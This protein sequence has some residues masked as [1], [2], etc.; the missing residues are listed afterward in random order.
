MMRKYIKI[1]V[2]CCIIAISRLF[3]TPIKYWCAVVRSNIDFGPNVKIGKHTYGITQKTIVIASSHCPASVVV[4]SFCS[5]APGVIILA[6][7]DH[8]TNLPS[9]FPFKTLLY[10]RHKESSTNYSNWDA[11]TKG[12]V[13]IG[14]DVWLGL[15]TIIL[16]GV[17]IGP[18]A[19]IGAGSVVT[20]D[21]PPYAIAVGNPAKVIKFRFSN[22]IIE[23]LLESEWWLFSDGMLKDLAPF[24][25]NSDISEFLEQVEVAKRKMEITSSKC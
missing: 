11:V 10:P 20:K 4:G 7:V 2:D 24:F 18:G 25:Y 1:C 9:T 5:F 21:I 14:H 12:P 13:E 15:N 3:D 19:V 17:K 22:E 6:N 16:S 8:P 23:R